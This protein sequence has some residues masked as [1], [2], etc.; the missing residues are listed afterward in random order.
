MGLDGSLGEGVS[1]KKGSTRGLEA[2]S[3]SKIHDRVNREL[4]KLLKAAREF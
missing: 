4:S 3:V 1:G 2:G